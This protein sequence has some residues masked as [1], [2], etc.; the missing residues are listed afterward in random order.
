M[1]HDVHDLS[2]GELVSRLSQEI[3]ELVRGELD[4]AK[5][6]LSGKAKAA[7]IGAGMFGAAGLI[8]LYGAGV[9]IAA[10]VLALALVLDAWLAALL[11]GVVVL[12]VA[13]VLA[14]L[15]RSR[16]TAATPPAP[17]RTVA[18]V[19]QDIETLKEGTGR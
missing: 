1:S 10:A 2:T 13:G 8:A 5:A 14:L 12:A 15:G 7:G 3:S 19:K 18:S 6:E 9:L 16:V 17:E 4:L 11:V